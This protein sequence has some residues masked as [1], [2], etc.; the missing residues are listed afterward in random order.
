MCRKAKKRK[1]DSR[2][3]QQTQTIIRRRYF[4]SSFV[5]TQHI[6]TYIFF[7]FPFLLVSFLFFARD[8]IRFSDTIDF[9]LARVERARQA[10]E[11]RNKSEQQRRRRP[12]RFTRDIYHL[13]EQ[14][15]SNRNE[16][17]QTKNIII[18]VAS[19][20]LPV[21]SIVSLEE[22]SPTLINHIIVK[23][24]NFTLAAVHFEIVTMIIV[25]TIT[26]WAW[27][28]EC[29]FGPCASAPRSPKAQSS[30]II[31]GVMRQ[32]ASSSNDGFDSCG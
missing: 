22:D 11:K 31:R 13:N 1:R 26:A 9:Q 32:S 14:T 10:G 28:P 6:F 2:R 19:W 15:E 20:Q 4:I 24:F 25:I 5:S 12:S 18:S 8:A 3:K 17:C 21:D 16:E 30:F 27:R 23:F 29:H 7:F